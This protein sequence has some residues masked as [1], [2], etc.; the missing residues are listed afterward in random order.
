MSEELY[1]ATLREIS[2]QKRQARNEEVRAYFND[3]LDDVKR[4]KAAGEDWRGKLA[5]ALDSSPPEAL[6]S[7]LQLLETLEQ[8]G[9]AEAQAAPPDEQERPEQEKEQKPLPALDS[10]Q[11]VETRA[12]T[13]EQRRDSARRREES[14]EAHLPLSPERALELLREA[15]NYLTEEEPIFGEDGKPLEPVLTDEDKAIFKPDVERLEGKIAAIQAEAEKKQRAV[16]LIEAARNAELS[17]AERLARLQTAQSAWEHAP[18]LRA[19]QD[20]WQHARGALARQA[21][22]K[23]DALISRAQLLGET[24][25][26][27]EQKIEALQEEL[28]ALRA[29]YGGLLAEKPD[30]KE[31]VGEVEAQITAL[32][33]AR[34]NLERG[35]ERPEAAQ[36]SRPGVEPAPPVPEETPTHSLEAGEELTIERYLQEGQYPEALREL[37]ALIE[38]VPDSARRQALEQRREEIEEQYRR[39]VQTRLAEARKV[40]EQHPDDLRKQREAWESVLSLNPEHPE[41]LAAK[42]ALESRLRL[43]ETLEGAIRRAR[44]ALE[45]RNVKAMR[46]ALEEM[47]KVGL[48]TFADEAVKAKVARAEEQW[49][50]QYNH[51]REKLGQVTT[52]ETE[53]RYREAYASILEEIRRDTPFI[54]DAATGEEIRPEDKLPEIRSKFLEGLRGILQRREEAA[55]ENLPLYPERALELLREARNYLTEEEPLF[56]QKGEPLKPVLTDENKAIFK[57]DVERLEKKIAAIQAEAEKKQRAVLLIEAALNVELSPAERLGKL[58]TAQSAWEHAPKLRAYQDAWQHAQNALVRQAAGTLDALMRRARLL[59]ETEADFEQ[60]IEALQEELNALRAQYGGLLDE[61]PDL[62]EKAD[63]VVERLDALREA[64]KEFERVQQKLAETQSELEDAEPDDEH[65]KIAE[66]LL[67]KIPG[68]YQDMIEYIRLEARLN[69]LQGSQKQWNSGLTAY[70]QRKWNLARENLQQIPAGE[71]GSYPDLPAYLDRL[72]AIE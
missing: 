61:K 7:A 16:L 71:E 62:K 1:Q 52:L 13:L 18:K 10:G 24:E 48:D 66:T 14:A 34:E 53:Q 35:E 68:K 31:K 5:Q 25:A 59:D 30:L 3:L 27:F 37:D 56:S 55:D 40:A 39:T 17:P 47:R 46:E 60:K 64:R 36:P 58:Q 26:D 67:R 44:E 9:G 21:A 12:E 41:A 57:P 23:L 49:S 42:Q 28:N 63:T 22:G 45:K 6:E 4:W 70:R 15:R 54:I 69:R 38:R 72:A 11:S 19:Y 32:Q 43:E 65:V 8:F 2:R 20:A 51:L 50:P 29:Q 33:Y